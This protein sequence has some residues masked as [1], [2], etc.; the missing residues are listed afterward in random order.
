MN[1]M[2]IYRLALSLFLMTFI[3]LLYIRFD[4]QTGALDCDL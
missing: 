4:I 1:V 2:Q 3:Y